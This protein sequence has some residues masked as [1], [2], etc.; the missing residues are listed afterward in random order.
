LCAGGK[1]KAD[2]DDQGSKWLRKFEM[3]HG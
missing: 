2:A 3:M 1:C